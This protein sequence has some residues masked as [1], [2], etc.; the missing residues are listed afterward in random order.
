MTL[1]ERVTYS[2]LAIQG[3]RLTAASGTSPLPAREKGDKSG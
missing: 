2:L 3:R 1:A